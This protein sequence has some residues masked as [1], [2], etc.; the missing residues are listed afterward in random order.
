MVIHQIV[1]LAV[2]RHL[3]EPTRPFSHNGT[4]GGSLYWNKMA[5]SSALQND[6]SIASNLRAGEEPLTQAESPRDF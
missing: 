5:I 2:F 6:R 4:T 1:V 3:I